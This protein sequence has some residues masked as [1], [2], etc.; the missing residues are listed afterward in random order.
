M[1]SRVLARLRP[2]LFAETH[3]VNLALF[4]VAVF[5][6]LLLRL[7]T[8][9]QQLLNF[10]SVPRVLMVAP[11]G[12]GGVLPYVPINPTIVS[13]AWLAMVTTVL[14]AAIGAWTAPAAWASAA[15][16][17]Y[18]L[19][20]PEFFGKVNH[21][22]QHLV[23]FAALLAVS[24]S[25]DALSVDAWR[26]N[27]DPGHGTALRSRVAYGLPLRFAWILIGLVYF[28]PG[29]AK[30]ASAG[31]GWNPRNHMWAKWYQL[32]GWM[33]LVRVDRYPILLTLIGVGTM[34]FELTFLFLVFTRRGR[35]LVTVLGLAFHTAI[36]LLMQINFWTLQAAYVGLVDW[37]GLYRRF[38][39]AATHAIAGPPRKAE[40]PARPL[41]PTVLVGSLLVGASLVAGGLR[42][43]S[44]WPL[45]AYPSFAGTGPLTAEVISL[46]AVDASGGAHAY[47]PKSALLEWMEL[48]R[49]QVLMLDAFRAGPAPDQRARAQALL[50][51]IAHFAPMPRGTV[52]VRFYRDRVDL[53]PSHARN[54]LGHELLMELP[55]KGGGP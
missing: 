15:L 35:R 1:R 41:R 51:V 53:D 18:V 14:L 50:Q 6:T 7:L 39:P 5:G 55:S 38:R 32:E 23:A 30:L 27:Q 21:F 12:L 10:S 54:P 47:S 52:A 9:R 26:H 49:Y 33:P 20:I 44:G 28:F 43:E 37:H 11:A 4:R 29:L 17:V 22:D 2:L 13:V 46:E 45:S 16:A 3:P 19:G 34:G 36:Y 8:A 31:L 40:V 48:E 24:P 42:V 25:A